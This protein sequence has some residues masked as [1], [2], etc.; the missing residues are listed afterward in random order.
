MRSGRI[1]IPFFSHI[2][3]PHTVVGPLAASAITLHFRFGALYLL[4][5][6]STAANTSTSHSFSRYLFGFVVSIVV[7]IDN[8]IFKLR[9]E[10]DVS[11]IIINLVARIITISSFVLVAF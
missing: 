5:T 1:W 11:K 7:S 3:S 4:I 10:L 2:S 8:L 6:L 9:Q